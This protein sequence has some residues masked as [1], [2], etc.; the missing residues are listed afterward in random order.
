MKPKI[1]LFRG[2]YCS[3]SIVSQV[4]QQ[5]RPTFPQSQFIPRAVDRDGNCFYG[6]LLKGMGEP[7]QAP[8]SADIQA[9][10]Q[11][12]AD[13]VNKHQ[14][15]LGAHPSFQQA[16]LDDL[17]ATIRTNG[18]WNSDGGDLVPVLAA[19]MVGCELHI[20]QN[21]DR[22]GEYVECAVLPANNLDLP[23]MESRDAMVTPPALYLL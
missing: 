20:L 2:C 8:D 6:A 23:R 4:A 9:L 19:H 5:Q 13:Y 17:E 11:G 7:E 15:M 22:A 18:R 16:S 3:K 10:R 1:N 12:I 14:D 21:G